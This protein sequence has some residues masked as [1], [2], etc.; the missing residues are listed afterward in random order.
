MTVRTV[1]TRSESILWTVVKL[2]K[3][4]VKYFYSIYVQ[5]YYKFVIRK[6]DED[7]LSIT[8]LIIFTSGLIS[9]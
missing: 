3:E 6:K 1:P 8:K 2:S 4:I 9:R 5:I 7:I